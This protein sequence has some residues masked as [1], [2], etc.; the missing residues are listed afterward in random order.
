M[1]D[2]LKYSTQ[3]K[4]KLKEPGDYN[5]ILLNDNYTPMDFVTAILVTIFNKQRGEAEQ[6]MLEVHN[7]GKGIAGQYTGDI[8]ITKM[9]Q[10]H[11]VAENNGFPLKCVVEKA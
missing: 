9:K 10:V 8:A 11:T 7:K 3:K 1:A 6:V 5:V 4:R 2:V